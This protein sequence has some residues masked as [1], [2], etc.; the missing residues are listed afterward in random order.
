M[1]KILT[2]CAL[3]WSFSLVQAQA[4]HT[5]SDRSTL[6]PTYA[7]FYHGVASGDPLMDRVII[8]TSNSNFAPVSV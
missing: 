7:P 6:D 2:L 3:L 1:K 4:G 8:W 5:R